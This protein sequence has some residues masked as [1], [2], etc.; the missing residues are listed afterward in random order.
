[1][2]SWSRKARMGGWRKWGGAIITKV[3]RHIQLTIRVE[4]VTD[5]IR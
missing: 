5:K 2:F 4:V 1:M 3:K